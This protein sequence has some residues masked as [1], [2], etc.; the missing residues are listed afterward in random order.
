MR[1][2]GQLANKEDLMDGGRDE[3][4]WYAVAMIVTN[5]HAWSLFLVHDFNVYFSFH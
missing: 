2:S 4:T 1:I 5:R 3:M